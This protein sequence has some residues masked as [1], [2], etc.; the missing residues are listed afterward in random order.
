MKPPEV[1][2]VWERDGVQREI[3]FV[4]GVYIVYYERPGLMDDAAPNSVSLVRV[5]QK[6][7]DDW[8]SKATLVEPKE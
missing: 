7:W 1:G 2:Q 8:A 4:F 6:D 5:I 3:Y